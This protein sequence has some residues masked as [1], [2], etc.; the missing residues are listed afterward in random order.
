MGIND[1]SET[2]YH[3]T[4]LTRADVAAVARG[5][6]YDAKDSDLYKNMR[7]PTIDCDTNN[8]VENVARKSSSKSETVARFYH[9]WALC[10]LHVVPIVD[11][12]IRPVCKQA[13]NKRRSDREKGR[14]EG[15]RLLN[16]A[17][18]IRLKHSKG[19]VV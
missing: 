4:G 8:V 17:K 7:L 12:E 6:F 10:G 5:L 11:G 14:I 15:F 1:G 9:E 18:K 2:L 19:H 13:S 3:L 16:E